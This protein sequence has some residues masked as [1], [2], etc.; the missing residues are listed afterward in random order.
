[1]SRA[2][3]FKSQLWALLIEGAPLE[4]L[5]LPT[6][7]G[8]L[9]LSA[10]S[11]AEPRVTKRWQTA[12]ANVEEIEP[13]PVV[14]NATW[15]NYDF[16][17]A[18]LE[19]LR[20]EDCE[21]VNCVF[22]RCK[23]RNI[24]IWNSRFEGC[25][26]RRSDLRN[27]SIGPASL[28]D[29]GINKQP[30][31]TYV[32]VDFS[33][34]DMRGTVYLIAAFVHCTFSRTKLDRVNFATSNFNSC[35]FEGEL[36][37][38]VFWRSD[39]FSRPGFADSDFPANEMVD[40]DFTQASL[41][42]VEFRKLTLDRARLP[43]GPDHIILEDYPGALDRLIETFRAANDRTARILLAGFEVDRKWA[44]PGGRGVLNIHDLADCGPDAVER[45]LA[46]LRECKA[47]VN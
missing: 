34:A 5:P 42:M 29:R 8:R 26:F 37:E 43:N 4:G 12:I 25:S 30:F 20:L 13:A 40:V 10:A 3:D 41:R 39:L 28:Q 7:G 23:M 32:E 47:R 35:R 2:L 38:V 14:R 19:S 44:P 33:G 21:I 22:D 31:N 17:G 46:V 9:D 18:S 11:L 36:R 16:S 45:V 24:R 6:K 27:S 15:R 1:M